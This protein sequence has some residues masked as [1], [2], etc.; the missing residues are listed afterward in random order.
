MIPLG[1]WE[2]DRSPRLNDGLLT[3][4]SGA[5][6]TKDGWRPCGGLVLLQNALPDTARGGA[7]FTGSLGTSVIIVGT[8][9]TLYRAYADGW[10]GISG[11]YSLQAS[12]RWRFAQFGD[13]GIA[14][15]GVDPLTKIELNS[16]VVSALGGSPPKFEMLG[17]VK[18]FLVG[19]VRDGNVMALGWSGINNAEFWTPGQRQSDYNIMPSGGAI[20]G[21]LSGEYGVILQR[22]RICRM[23]YVGGNVIF[24][25][26]EV[27]SN[28]GCVSKNSVAQWGG[29]GFFLSDEGFMMWDGASPQPIGEERLNRWFF[30]Q[31]TVSDFENMSTAIDPVNSCVKWSMG[32]KILVFNWVLNKWGK[33]PIAAEI[34]FSG[35]SKS[36]GIDEQ[37][38]DFG[39]LDDDIDG[40]G[41]PSLDDPKFHGGDPRLYV[42]TSSGMGTLTDDPMAASFTLS[43][44]E[45]FPG[46][47]ANLRFIRPDIDAVSGVTAS[48]RG[49]Q[50]L[51]DAYDTIAA[52][53]MVS[54]GE[55]PVRFSG[56][57]MKPTINVAQ[58]ASWA[59]ARGLEFIGEAG[60]GR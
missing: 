25:I 5:Y 55:M 8:E 47:R 35:V 17:V 34:I 41:L 15:N 21:I 38:P 26:N 56:R 57:Y 1:P 36:L 9:T 49:K 33:L 51:G 42:V 4:V 19:G 23:D 6:P 43:D 58:G 45:L 10:D 16:L 31:Y 54:S 20:T 37:D 60:A 7:T 14:T 46:K 30:D 24:Q 52:S 2:P 59:Y 13:L 44:I 12:N 32:D 48:L 27:S 39:A 53:A 40:V 22:N 11:G 50:R 28:I 3:D 29:L 18:D